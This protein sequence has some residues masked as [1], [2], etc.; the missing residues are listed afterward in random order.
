MPLRSSAADHVEHL[1]KVPLFSGMSKKDLQK[2]AK[3][4]DEVDAGRLGA[5]STKPYTH[6]G[7]QASALTRPLDE[8]RA[9]PP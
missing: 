8:S 1:A 2:L 4:S 5:A 9:R 3:V 7:V 6:G